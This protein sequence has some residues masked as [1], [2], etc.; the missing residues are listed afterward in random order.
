[1]FVIVYDSYGDSVTKYHINLIVLVCTTV[2]AE[3][4]I[5]AALKDYKVKQEKKGEATEKMEAAV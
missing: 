2:L 1:M 5:K 4:A 3:D